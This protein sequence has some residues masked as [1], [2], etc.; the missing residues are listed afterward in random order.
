MRQLTL[1]LAL[2]A[3]TLVIPSSATGQANDAAT[4]FVELSLI[5]I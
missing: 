3:A 1:G 4:R 2:V 5:H